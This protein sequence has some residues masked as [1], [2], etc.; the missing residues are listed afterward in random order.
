MIELGGIALG[1]PT[2][3]PFVASDLGKIFGGIRDVVLNPTVQKTVTDYLAYRTNQK[4]LDAAESSAN[5]K[6]ARDYRLVLQENELRK[7][8]IEKGYGYDPSAYLSS[9]YLGTSPD[10]IYYPPGVGMDVRSSASG[11]DPLVW[12]A[13][14]VGVLFLMGGK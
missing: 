7:L 8:A 3:A 9:R 4:A 10:P 11:Q 14:G 1:V 13:I 6:A 2:A 12:I 5:A